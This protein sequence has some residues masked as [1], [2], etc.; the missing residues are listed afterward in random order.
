[1]RLKRIARLTNGTRGR[2]VASKPAIIAM[3]KVFTR[4]FAGEVTREKCAL[5]H[6]VLEDV[7]DAELDVAT[8]H[9]VRTHRGEFI[10]PAAVVRDA[11]GANRA[12]LIDIKTL[13]DKITALGAYHVD[14]AQ[15]C[16]PALTTIAAQL[17]DEI[18]RA[19]SAAGATLLF[20]NS[21]TTREIAEREFLRALERAAKERPA[22]TSEL[23]AL[24]LPATTEQSG[25]LR[26]PS[27]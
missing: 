10:P 14:S 20:S 12:P 27:S 7:T 17:G 6:S 9:L 19:Y 5:Y 23:H 8:M 24:S 1:M 22:L 18:A 3:M 13:K 4:N 15:W 16:Y 11:A 25:A 21:D 26:L 2:R